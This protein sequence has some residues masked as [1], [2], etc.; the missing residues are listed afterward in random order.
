MSTF[1]A[2]FQELLPM[3]TTWLTTHVSTARDTCTR[4]TS[5][6]T[7]KN[8]WN[9]C[10]TKSTTTLNSV[11]AD[12][13]ELESCTLDTMLSGDSSFT[14]RTQVVIMP[15]GRPMPPAKVAWMPSVR[16]RKTTRRTAR[17]MRHSFWPWEC[18]E[19]LW[20]RPRQIQTCSKL[21]SCR[22]TPVAI[23]FRGKLKVPN[24]STY[25]KTIRFSMRTR[26]SE[27]GNLNRVMTIEAWL[28]TWCPCSQFTAVKWSNNEFKTN[29]ILFTQ[30]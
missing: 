21:E 29:I 18:S 28:I 24:W 22:R 15:R 9:S 7:W 3:P 27:Q 12:L 17:L 1:S 26:R 5:K 2:R 25:L 10:A 11:Q 23:S 6:S 13:S 8:S 16:S 19:N 20:T 14:T 30:W 4:T